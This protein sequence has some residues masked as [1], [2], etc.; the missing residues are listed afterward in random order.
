MKRDGMEKGKNII[1]VKIILFNLKKYKK[2]R[3]TWWDKLSNMI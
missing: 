2:I 1:N 3:N